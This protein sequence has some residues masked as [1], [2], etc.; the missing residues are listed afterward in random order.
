[1]ERRIEG[2]EFDGW[3]YVRIVSGFINV[4]MYVLYT[5]VSEPHLKE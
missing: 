2:R 3:G 4:S 1:M 5:F